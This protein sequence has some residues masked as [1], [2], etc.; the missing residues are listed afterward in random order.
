VGESRDGA[1]IQY[2]NNETLNSGTGSS[3]VGDSAGSP[4]GGRAVMLAEAADMLVLDTLTHEEHDAALGPSRP[5]RNHVLQQRH[6]RLVAKNASFYSEQ[7]TLN[8]KGWAWFY[9]TLVA[10]NVDFIWGSSRA[11]LFEEQR[12]PLGRR[13]H[14]RHQRRLRAA[15]ARAQ[16]H[17][18]RLRLP[19]QQPDARR[20]PRTA[21]RRRA[22]RRH[23]PGAQPGR[24]A[25]WDNIA[26]INCRMD[27]HVATGWAG[28]GVNGQPAPNPVVPAADSG[29]REYGSTTLNGTPINLA[30]R[31]GGFQLS[32]SDVA[33]GFADRARVFSAYGSGAG[34]NPQP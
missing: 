15:G 34:W 7:D 12:D 1:V 30:A 27:A 33:A 13:H 23:L 18:H 9:N 26:F 2:T 11:A 4:A 3:Q 20:R 16:R 21:A 10:G 22:G 8:L 28:L 25:S 19:E 32:A 14:Q 17:R 29:W 31:V 5:G 6:R 24:H